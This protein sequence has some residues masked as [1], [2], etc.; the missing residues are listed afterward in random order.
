MDSDDFVGLREDEATVA[1]YNNGF[2]VVR[3]TR[4]DGVSYPA[5]RDYRTDRIN[6]NVEEMLIVAASVG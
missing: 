5:T 1:A 6:F 2:C 3:I 4:R